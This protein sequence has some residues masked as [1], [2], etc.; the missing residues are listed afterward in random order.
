MS[1]EPH[2]GHL[3][4]LLLVNSSHFFKYS[5]VKFPYKLYIHSITGNWV[6]GLIGLGG[7]ISRVNFSFL[8]T[9]AESEQ[10]SRDIVVWWVEV[11]CLWVEHQGAVT[12]SLAPALLR[13]LVPLYSCR[14]QP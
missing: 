5:Q 6:L 14:I 4:L 11:W 12:S 7:T 3:K 13:V 10:I 1:E 2:L 9:C 8:L